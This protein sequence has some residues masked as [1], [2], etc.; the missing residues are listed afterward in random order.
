MHHLVKD[1][2]PQGFSNR[3]ISERVRNNLKTEL[4]VFEPP[5]AV[6]GSKGSKNAKENNRLGNIASNL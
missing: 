4:S 3:E 6:M 1:R 2:P 5:M